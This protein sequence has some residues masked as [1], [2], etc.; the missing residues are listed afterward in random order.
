M[1]FVSLDELRRQSPL[2]LKKRMIVKALCLPK[3]A[4]MAKGYHLMVAHNAAQVRFTKE[5]VYIFL[6]EKYLNLANGG[7]V[8]N[9]V[10]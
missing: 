4:S 8:G 5:L 6:N 7:M 9:Y 3:V 1:R 10:H 2:P